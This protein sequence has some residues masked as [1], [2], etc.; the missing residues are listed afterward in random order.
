MD[1][2][3]LIS[4]A[5]H[6]ARSKYGTLNRSWVAVSHRIGG[7][8]PHSLLS[9]SVQRDGELDLVLRCMEDEHA[10][11]A[12]NGNNDDLFGFH[13]QKM[14]SDLWVGSVYETLRLLNE[15]KLAPS[16]DEFKRLAHEFRLLR[17]PLEKHEL[18]GKVTEPLVMQK[19]PPNGDDTDYYTYPPGR[20]PTRAH[21]MPTG[22]SARGSVMWQ[23]ID[24]RNDT[25]FWLERRELADRLLSLWQPASQANA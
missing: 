19:F 22:I 7:R 17:V 3:K 18:A 10:S 2:T 1:V 12:Q 5:F 13:Y 8:L 9:M 14:L 21:I 11:L 15:R 6:V 20:D 24:V 25:S 4:T 23:V 16:S